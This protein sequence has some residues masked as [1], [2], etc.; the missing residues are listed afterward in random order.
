MLLTEDLEPILTQL[1]EKE[2]SFYE[3]GNKSFD[4]EVLL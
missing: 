4:N 1:N 2:I 3:Y